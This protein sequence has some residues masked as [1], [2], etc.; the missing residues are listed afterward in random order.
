[1][2]DHDALYQLAEQQAGYFA[3]TR[4]REPGFSYSLL[5]FHVGTDRFERVRPRAYRLV[6]FPVAVHEKLHAA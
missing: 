5:S 4:A 2:P 3:A 1:M 6:Q